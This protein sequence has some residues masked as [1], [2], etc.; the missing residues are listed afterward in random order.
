[1][2]TRRCSFCGWVYENERLPAGAIAGR[3]ATSGRSVS[4]APA[5]SRLRER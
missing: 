3:G 4:P 5:S 2:T 1:M